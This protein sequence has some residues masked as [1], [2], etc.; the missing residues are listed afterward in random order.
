MNTPTATTARP[1]APPVTTIAGYLLTRLEEA[2]V[3]SVFGVP[4]DYNLGVLDAVAARPAMA[5]LLQ[6]LARVL[7]SASHYSRP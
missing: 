2:G 3:I 1:S 5:S 6:D 4:G 7:A